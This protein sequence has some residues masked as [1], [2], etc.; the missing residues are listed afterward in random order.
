[1]ETESVQQL[2]D[3]GFSVVEVLAAIVLLSLTATGVAGMFGVALHA[4]HLARNQTSTATLAVQ[5][6]EQLRALT[7]GFEGAG[8]FLPVTDTT[9]DLSQAVPTGAGHGL[10]ASPADSLDV[11]R[12]GYVDYLDRHGAWVGTGT[13]IPA[14]AVYVRRWNVRPLPANPDNTVVLQVL[15]TTVQ[16]ESTLTGSAGPRPRLPGDAL[17]ATVKTRKAPG[18]EP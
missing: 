3:S 8:P 18:G 1:M 9:T 10:N 13:D 5:K 6:M 7:W 4:T 12:P 16:R 11:N 17:I 14:T 2:H 15:A